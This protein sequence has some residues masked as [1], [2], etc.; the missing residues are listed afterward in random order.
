MITEAWV[1]SYIGLWVLVIVLLV[2][3][4][5]LARQIGLIYRRLPPAVARMTSEGPTVGSEMEEIAGRTL[6][7]RAI[8]IGGPNLRPRL[9]VFVGANCTSCDELAP[10][11]RS[12]H[13]SDRDDFEVMIVGLGGTD[14]DNRQFVERNR[15]HDL[16]FSISPE[17]IT[18]YG[19]QGTPYAMLTDERGRVRTKGIANHLE[20]LESLIE[21]VLPTQHARALPV[22]Q[23]A[24]GPQP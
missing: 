21:G 15:L 16:A 20:Q 12:I 19:I 1:A 9:Y 13:A 3:T 14:E 23:P 7:G 8:S 18:T 24:T 17:A 10:A 5:A 6:H 11:L 4:V 22:A 2:L